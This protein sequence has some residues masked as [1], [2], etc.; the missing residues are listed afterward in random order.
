MSAAEARRSIEDLKPEN[1]RMPEFNKLHGADQ[2]GYDP[3]NFW[4]VIPVEQTSLIVLEN[5]S[6][7]AVECEDESVAS[8]TAISGEG[9]ALKRITVRGHAIG[10]T[11]LRARNSD[12]T[13]SDVQSLDIIV[14]PDPKYRLAGGANRPITSDARSLIPQDLREAVLWVARDQ[15]N[16]R[17]GRSSGGFGTYCDKGY[18]WC[19]AFA[20]FCWQTAANILGK[21]NPFGSNIDVLLSPQKAITWAMRDESPATVVQYKGPAP[22]TGKM[23]TNPNTWGQISDLQQADICLL[24]DES[25]WRHVCMIYDVDPNNFRTIDGNQGYPCIKV[26][27]RNRDTV[28]RIGTFKHSFLHVLL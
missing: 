14:A 26:V 12:G 2:S 24:R 22:M 1:K 25:N 18:D 10:S 8:V 27:N 11:T 9:T 21:T 4:Q 7:L 17:I 15:M 6:D 5:G 3:E 19:G 16:S 13:A 28:L 23:P 20:F